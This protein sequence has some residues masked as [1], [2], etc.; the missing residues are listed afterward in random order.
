M[1]H[2]YVFLS[3]CVGGVLCFTI[4]ESTSEKTIRVLLVDGLEFSDELN[5]ELSVGAKEDATGSSKF[6]SGHI[7]WGR[8]IPG[9]Y[10]PPRLL[11]QLCFA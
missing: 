1:R 7:D 4:V 8:A 3:F 9:L 2:V 11:T 10:G 6:E 5:G